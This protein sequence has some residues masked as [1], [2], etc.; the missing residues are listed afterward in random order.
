MRFKPFNIRTATY[1]FLVTVGQCFR[2]C[3]PRVFFKILNI[4]TNFEPRLSKCCHDLMVDNVEDRVM[5]P[6]EV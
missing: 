4:H 1:D 2:N 6:E 3:V 5:L